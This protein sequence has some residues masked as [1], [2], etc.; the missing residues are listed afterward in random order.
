[1]LWCWRVELGSWEIDMG[2]VYYAL[3]EHCSDFDDVISRLGA[4]WNWFGLH[5][6][7]DRTDEGHVLGIDFSR[8]HGAR[9]SYSHIPAYWFADA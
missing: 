6:W 4:L 7:H 8:T 3:P 9:L 1:M 2:F 5:M